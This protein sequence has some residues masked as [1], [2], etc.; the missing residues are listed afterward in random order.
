M[1]K[2]KYYV[3][4]KGRKPGIYSTWSECQEQID[5][6]TGQQFKSFDN[7]IDAQKA[8]AGHYKDYEG[9]ST[10]HIDP[11]R[12][13]LVGEPILQSWAVDAACVAQ[14]GAM[15]YRIVNTETKEPIYEQ[16]TNNIGEFLALVHAL[17]HCKRK[18]LT[19][20][21]YSDSQIAI[22][23]VREKFCNTRLKPTEENQVLRD[24]VKRAEKWLAENTY[25]NAIL[26]WETDV[27]GE[28]PADYGRK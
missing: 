21:I 14:T 22:T 17:G 9:K 12:R 27:W 25:E 8:F 10:K 28:N 24:L 23:W 18:G 5:G 16:G 2:K 15:E 13:Q 4:W 3:V 20:P 6:F 19:I 26:K 11:I 1:A 7:L